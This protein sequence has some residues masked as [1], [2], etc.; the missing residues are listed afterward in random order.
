M[1]SV[2]ACLDTSP[3]AASVLAAAHDLARRS[4][5]SLVLFRSVGLPP[6]LEGELLT[7]AP[8]DVG[9]ELLRRA[10]ADLRDRAAALTPGAVADVRVRIGVAWDAICTEARELDCDVI[11]I[12]SHGYTVLDRLVGTTA[13]KVVN[14]ADRSVLVVRAVEVAE[15]RDANGGGRSRT[16]SEDVGRGA[17]E[18]GV[19]FA[20]R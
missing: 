16:G 4:G 14:H 17:A 8:Q 10:E 6:E 3:R 13:A 5:A 1:K 18:R 20:A 11:V 2:M 7:M 9:G 15:A 12:G 19:T